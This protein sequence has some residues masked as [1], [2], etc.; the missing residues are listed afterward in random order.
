MTSWRDTAA[1]VHQQLQAEDSAL[2]FFGVS[3]EKDHWQYLWSGDF[4][5]HIITIALLM[6]L[7]WGSEW[8]Y[9]DL[10]CF[11]LWIGGCQCHYSNRELGNSSPA[12]SILFQGCSGMKDCRVSLSFLSHLYSWIVTL[13][14][15]LETSSAGSREGFLGGTQIELSSSGGFVVSACMMWGGWDGDETD[16]TWKQ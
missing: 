11:L 3:L 15:D 9:F 6:V 10:L 14:T 12:C 13:H 8:G 5:S 7:G 4:L 2:H 16:A 1:D